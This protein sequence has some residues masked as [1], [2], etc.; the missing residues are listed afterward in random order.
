M[1]CSVYHVYFFKIITTF[2]FSFAI[3]LLAP[4]LATW[5]QVCYYPLGLVCVL[6]I[7][8]PACRLAPSPASL[9]VHSAQHVLSVCYQH[10]TYSFSCGA[11]HCACG[12]SNSTNALHSKFCCCIVSPKGSF[13]HLLHL[14]HMAHV[15]VLLVAVNRARRLTCA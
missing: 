10:T 12:G 13:L 9:P 15:S 8:C 1:Y 14:V 2:S 4:A 5:F 11:S 7:I 3:F 6:H